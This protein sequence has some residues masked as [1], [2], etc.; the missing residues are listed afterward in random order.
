MVSTIIRFDNFCQIYDEDNVDLFKALDKHLSFKIQGA[1]HSKAF[2]GYINDR[3]E[4]VTW[5]GRRHIMTSKGRFPAGLLQRV[6]EF[7]NKWQVSPEVIDK[8]SE[9][10]SGAPI[11]I[12]TV[13]RSMRKEPRDYQIETANIA[14]QHDRGII[15][16]ATGSGKSLIAALITAKIGK[17]T[18]IYVIGT[19]LL[20]QFHKFFTSI[21]GKDVG[22]IGDGNCDIKDINIATVWSVGQALGLKKSVSLDDD[23]TEEKKIDPLKFSQIK[24]ML[25][26]TKVHLFDECHLA[27]CD[28]IQTIAQNLKAEY[29]YGMSASPWRDDG[30]D[31]LIEALLGRRIVDIGARELIK[32]GWL[33]EPDIR[34]LAPPPYSK[35]GKYQTIY[36]KYIVEHEARNQMVVKGAIKLVEQGFPCLVLFHSIRHGKILSD[37]LSK[38]IPIGL[39]SGK[40]PSRVRE[41]VKDDLETGRINCIVASK[42]F[43]IGV[44]LPT[45]SG[46]VIAGAGKSSV[47]ALQRIGRVIRPSPGKTMSAIIDFADRAPYL[48]DHAE[49]RRDI[50]RQEFDNVSWP[51]K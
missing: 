37:L 34:F 28:T 8:R 5:D 1:E 17:P 6:I 29:V 42:I 35:K 36:S 19:D 50:Y 11:D 18:I 10:S 46:L 39:L 33:V 9:R 15:R 31:L 27:A 24:T 2:K 32:Q 12:E 40:D 25:L 41:K 44:D 26:H 38:Q 47:R 14:V 20:Y 3:G 23:D 51:Q 22:I 43:D 7:Y 30:A 21:F 13:L 48:L 16:S 45:L 49:A 4:E